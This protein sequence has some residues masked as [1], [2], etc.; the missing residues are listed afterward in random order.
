MVAK[1]ISMAMVDFV[2]YPEVGFDITGMNAVSESMEKAINKIVAKLRDRGYNMND[3]ELERIGNI[4][5]VTNVL[6]R[7]IDKVNE[8]FSAMNKTF[9]EQYM[10]SKEILETMKIEV[11]NEDSMS[12]VVVYR[13]RVDV[14]LGNGQVVSVNT[15]EV[16]SVKG[17]DEQ[18]I[19]HA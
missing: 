10:L 17:A 6:N 5:Q 15:N 18:I 16:K 8:Y 9:S 4:T 2:N 11:V 7:N 12:N 14:E 19:T 13:D 3:I 1:V